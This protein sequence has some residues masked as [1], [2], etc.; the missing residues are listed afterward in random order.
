MNLT[1]LIVA[2]SI[3]ALA[4]V[5]SL[6]LRRYRLHIKS[7]NL[8]SQL[9]PLDLEAF[10]NLI[11]PAED[12][13]LRAHL[14]RFSYGAVRRARL[15]AMAA[16]VRLALRN[17][18]VLAQ[19]GQAASRNRDPQKA[20]AARAMSNDA[21]LLRR[22]AT[23]ALARVYFAMVWPGAGSS[24]APFQSQYLRVVSSA[25]LFGRLQDPA[26]ASRFAVADQ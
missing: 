11:D 14:S 22:N 17:A 1:Y 2:G 19:I 26:H 20:A 3:L 5:L 8:E 15:R 25:M 13:Y 23:I 21:F 4:G 12:A 16:Y 24:L 18:A 7:V 9:V 10:R 6:G